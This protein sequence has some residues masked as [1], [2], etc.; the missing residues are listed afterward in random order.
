M[1]FTFGEETINLNVPTKSFLLDEVASRLRRRQGFAI[2]TL[3]MDHLVKLAS[4]HFR[5][6]YA[7]QDLITA[8]GNPIVWLSHVARRPVELVTGSD[9]IL[10]LIRIA[11]SENARIGMFGSSA[12]TLSAA[13]EQLIRR[14]PGVDIGSLIAPPM[15]FDPE[16][17]EAAQAI[18]S[19]RATGVRMVFVALGAPKQEMFAALGRKLAPEIGFVSIGAGLDFIAGTQKRAPL[20]VRHIAMEW[21]WRLL[22][23][24]RRM[25][26]RYANCMRIL[27]RH[28][29]DAVRLRFAATHRPPVARP[30]DVNPRALGKVVAVEITSERIET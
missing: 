3:N 7:A 5:K 12:E 18:Q 6:A 29:A 2:A 21:M 1:L 10:P 20:W 19:F 16:G 26:G 30:I 28:L 11:A 9:L 13:R 17:L 25:Y 27:P 14:V 22:H 24:P 23:D 4:E 15:G 8:D